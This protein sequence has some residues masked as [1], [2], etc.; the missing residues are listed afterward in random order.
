MNP[1][2]NLRKP[3]EIYNRKFC[4]NSN[5]NSNDYLNSI[6]ADGNININIKENQNENGNGNKNSENLNHKTFIEGHRG[7]FDKVE[8]TLKAF[9]AAIDIECDCI[10]L[11]V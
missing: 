8:N 5:N 3:F 9:K 2:K 10:E 1:E 6:P 4:K 11:D 7:V